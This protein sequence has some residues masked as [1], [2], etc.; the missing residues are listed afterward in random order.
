MP[1]LPWP[2]AVGYTPGPASVLATGG[3]GWFSDI[4]RGRFQLPGPAALGGHV[5][6]L[7]AATDALK[8]PAEALLTPCSGSVLARRALPAPNS[9]DPVLVEDVER[10]LAASNLLFEPAASDG[11]EAS[12][13]NRHAEHPTLS[14]LIRTP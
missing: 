1:W 5:G 3:Q 11:D 6:L 10:L 13:A 7:E 2:S 12:E 9:G 4:P 8:G 14:T